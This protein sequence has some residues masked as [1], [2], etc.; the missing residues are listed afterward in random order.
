VAVET[1]D[2]LVKVEF[3]DEAKQWQPISR[4]S[5]VSPGK[6]FF[7]FTK[8]GIQ[9]VVKEMEVLPGKNHRVVVPQM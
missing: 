5:R 9:P 2:R 6:V 1:R 4:N 3:Q 7:R 8:P